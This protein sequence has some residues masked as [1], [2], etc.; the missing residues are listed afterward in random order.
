MVHNAKEIP[1]TRMDCPTCI[2]ALEKSIL[3]VKGVKE[4][5]GNYLKNTI[6]VT[7]DSSTPLESIEKAIED[8]GYQVAYK[9]YPNAISRIRGLFSKETSK[10]G[11]VTITD[12]DFQ[13]KVLHSSKP[14]VLLFSSETCPSCQMIKLTIKELAEKKN[15]NALF[16]EMDVSETETWKKY[17]VL[18]IPTVIIFRSGMPSKRYSAIL[19]IEEI[20]KDLE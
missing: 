14:V 16:F 20:D 4:A 2:L 17:S 11:F 6:K 7:Y 12:K 18:G 8:V 10:L 5:R 19:R 9:K 15:K 13:E 1:I 3:A